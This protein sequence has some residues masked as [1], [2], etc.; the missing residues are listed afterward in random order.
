MVAH[1]NLFFA[2]REYWLIIRLVLSDDFKQIVTFPRPSMIIL[3]NS[4][5]LAQELYMVL[6]SN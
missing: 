5:R 1:A 4:G 6:K 3:I 2:V